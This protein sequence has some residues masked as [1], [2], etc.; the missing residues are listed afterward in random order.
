MKQIKSSYLE[1][2]V[3]VTDVE[4]IW[5]RPDNESIL[6]MDILLKLEDPFPV[7]E[8]AIVNLIKRGPRSKF[9]SRELRERVKGNSIESQQNMPSSEKCEVEDDE[10][11]RFEPWWVEIR[12]S[13]ACF[14]I[15]VETF[16]GLKIVLAL[17]K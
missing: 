11:K 13:Q 15:E 4:I 16:A 8:K 9:R 14:G 1:E 17:F 6:G 12:P 2:G 10:I 5:P 7:F 3:W